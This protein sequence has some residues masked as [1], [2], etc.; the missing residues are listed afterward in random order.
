LRS[1]LL[2]IALVLLA[3]SPAAAGD[4]SGTITIVPLSV[5]SRVS[6]FDSVV[7]YID[8][9]PADPALKPAAAPYTIAQIDRAFDPP[10]LIVPVGAT[11]DFPNQDEVFHNVFSTAGGNAFDLGLYKSGASKSM[12]FTAPGMVPIF[13]NIHPKMAAHVLVVANGFH[14]RPNADGRFRFAGLPPGKYHLVAWFPFGNAERVEVQVG[15][16]PTETHA[17]VTL[18]ERL[19]AGSHLDKH[20]KPYTH[21]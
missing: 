6:G 10:L 19:G 12:T 5:G 9:A 16:G 4:L 17:D 2:A 7:V 3:A 11:V 20:G 1:S 8:D 21:Y 14:T 13:C 15:V 18:R